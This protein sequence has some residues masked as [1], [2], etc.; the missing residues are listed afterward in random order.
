[1]TLQEQSVVQYKNEINYLHGK[2]TNLKRDLEYQEK[3]SEK[4]RM[5]NMKLV[6]EVMLLK[7]QL[8]L[9]DKEHNLLKRQ[10]NGLEEDNDR[11]NRLYQVVE[12]EA[13]SANS[14]QEQ[15]P[16]YFKEEKEV[17]D[18]KKE[19]KEISEGGKWKNIDDGGFSSTG[20]F[21]RKGDEN[22]VPYDQRAT[23]KRSPYI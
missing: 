3:Y 11:I 9:K 13:F 21:G 16:A 1:M 10:I 20:N 18:F 4:Y 6:D 15:K 7:Q 2:S 22:R 12:R 5:E 14:K 17:K 23:V 8:E 19:E